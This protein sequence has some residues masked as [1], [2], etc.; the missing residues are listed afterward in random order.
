MFIFILVVDL[1][2]SR[3]IGD[4]LQTEVNVLTEVKAM[5]LPALVGDALQRGFVMT[6]ELKPLSSLQEG[7][8]KIHA[9]QLFAALASIHQA[10]YVTRDVRPTNLMVSLDGK[11]AYITDFGF[12]TKEGVQATYRGTLTTA[13]NRVLEILA[14]D[15][16]A[17]VGVT[18]A[19]EKESLI[20]VEPFFLFSSLSSQS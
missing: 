8:E 10:G 18:F 9:E 17:L 5:G 3:V 6:P 20:K 2:F 11:Q 14:D 15:R 12:A 13:S 4:C 7:L 1:I 16:Q 19:D